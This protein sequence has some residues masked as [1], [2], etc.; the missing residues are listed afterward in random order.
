MFNNAL[1]GVFNVKDSSLLDK[2]TLDIDTL[3]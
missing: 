1:C 3:T 2:E